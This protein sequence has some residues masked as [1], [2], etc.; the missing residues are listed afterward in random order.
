MKD[1]KLKLRFGKEKTP[2][3]HFTVL[4]DGIVG[5]LKEGFDCRPGKAWMSMK[6]WST[7][8]D[9]SEEMI[10]VI[11]AQIGFTVT[12]KIQVY[13]TEPIEAPSDNPKGYDINFRPYDEA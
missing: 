9:E 6:T 13:K 7:S 4:A 1:W 11:G 3:T 10:R 5:E 12:G 8:A 2:Y